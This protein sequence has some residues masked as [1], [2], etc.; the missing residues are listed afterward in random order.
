LADT[1]LPEFEKDACFHPFLKAIVCRRMRAQLGLVQ[2]LPLTSGSQDK[3][4]CIGAVS[5]R[6][7]RSSTA[8]AMRIDTDWE[9]WMQDGP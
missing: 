5:I 7:T 1:S 6:N 4:D 8:K 9:Q 3:E 2:R